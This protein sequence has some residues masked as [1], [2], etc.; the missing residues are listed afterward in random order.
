MGNKSQFLIQQDADDED[1]Q[2]KEGIDHGVTNS[3]RHVSFGPLVDM[4]TSA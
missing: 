4:D 3:K 2:F 1:G